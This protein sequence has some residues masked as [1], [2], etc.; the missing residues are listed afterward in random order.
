MREGMIWSELAKDSQII[1]FNLTQ[2]MIR[3]F[4]GNWGLGVWVGGAVNQHTAGFQH[5]YP[6]AGATRIP[7][8]GQELTFTKC[9]PHGRHC[10]E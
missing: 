10:A 3:S 8:E 6:Q 2:R 1:Y 4:L 7:H 9:L 5:H